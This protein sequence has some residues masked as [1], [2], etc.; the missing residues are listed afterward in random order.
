MQIGYTDTRIRENF[1]LLT[2]L[3]FSF[4]KYPDVKTK[5]N[6]KAKTRAKEKTK[7]ISYANFFTNKK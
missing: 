5:T 3:L 7:G 2:D 1:L 4:R 6:A